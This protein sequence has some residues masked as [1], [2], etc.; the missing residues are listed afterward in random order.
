MIT[1]VKSLPVILG[2]IVSVGGLAVVQT[3]AIPVHEYRITNFQPQNGITFD[4]DLAYTTQ[5]ALNAEKD[6]AFLGL[7]SYSCTIA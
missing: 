3:M 1:Y 4:I 6:I 7:A 5:G 2:L